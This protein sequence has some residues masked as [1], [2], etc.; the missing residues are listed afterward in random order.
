MLFDITIGLKEAIFEK[1][2]SNAMSKKAAFILE[3][4]LAKDKNKD[5]KSA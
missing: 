4:W 3:N 1:M 5:K 2:K